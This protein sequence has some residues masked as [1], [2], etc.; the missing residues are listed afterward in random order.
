MTI[1]HVAQKAPLPRVFTSWVCGMD[2]ATH[3]TAAQKLL[4]TGVTPFI[5]APQADPRRAIDFYG[6]HVLPE[7]HT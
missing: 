6:R 3:I 2:P 5:Y 7:L 4:D 1:E